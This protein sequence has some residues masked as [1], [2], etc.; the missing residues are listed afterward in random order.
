MNEQFIHVYTK[1]RYRMAYADPLGDSFML[2]PF[3]S[4]EELGT[5]VV[6]ALSKSRFLSVAEAEQLRA[7]AEERQGIWIDQVCKRYGYK[8]QRVLF[9]GM[10]NCS[11]ECADHVLQIMP[12]VQEK[13][14]GWSG[15][16]IAPEDY[17][18]ITDTSSD[19]EVGAALRLAFSRCR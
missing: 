4:N 3:V 1:S 6:S 10:K 16:D 15:D 11:I 14:G 7:G 19:S 8:S 9:K 17:V 12:S 5:A 2:S 18:S 13:S